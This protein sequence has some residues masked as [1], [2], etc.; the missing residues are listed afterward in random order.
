MMSARNPYLLHRTE[1]EAFFSKIV[2]TPSK[3]DKKLIVVDKIIVFELIKMHNFIVFN[4]GRDCQ[5][6]PLTFILNTNPKNISF[7]DDQNSLW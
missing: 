7:K 4:L 3:S 1:R 2:D 6:T 5:L